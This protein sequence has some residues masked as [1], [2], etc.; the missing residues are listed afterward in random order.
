MA[1]KYILSIQ[2][3]KER[4]NDNEKVY[5]K[6]TGNKYAINISRMAEDLSEET[7]LSFDFKL[8]KEEYDT[9]WLFTMTDPFIIDYINALVAKRVARDILTFFLMSIGNKVGLSDMEDRYRREWEDYAKKLI[10]EKM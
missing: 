1:H 2:R 3:K 5:Y 7:I 10:H 6:S 9:A 8:T 4:I